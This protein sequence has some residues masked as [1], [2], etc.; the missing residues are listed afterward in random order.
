M[1]RVYAPP[2]AFEER[3]RVCVCV[4]GKEA[5]R[6]VDIPQVTW[7]VNYWCCSLSH[8]SYSFLHL[9]SSHF[10]FLLLTIF[11]TIPF[12]SIFILFACLLCKNLY[13]YFEE[14]HPVNS[15]KIHLTHNIQRHLKCSVQWTFCH[16]NRDEFK[17]VCMR[18]IQK[19]KLNRSENLLL[20]WSFHEMRFL[21]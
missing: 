20:A 1:V 17:I 2:W 8:I 21:I 12:P 19:S 5:R 10:L 16:L 15:R 4:L 13:Y 6:P 7:P 9:F 11:Q 18:R 14:F 3:E